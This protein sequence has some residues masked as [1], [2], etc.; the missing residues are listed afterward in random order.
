MSRVKITVH[1]PLDHADAV[2]RALGD[3]GAG[4]QGN[5][6]HCSFSTRGIGRLT[7]HEG[8]RPFIGMVG[9]SETIEEERIEVICERG[10]A[11]AII[12]AMKAVHPYEEVAFDIIA[13]IE[14]DAL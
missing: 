8:A 11:K 1:A 6:S 2:R 9:S 5:Y 4:I 10:E 3:A 13:L 7:P 14:E 12:A